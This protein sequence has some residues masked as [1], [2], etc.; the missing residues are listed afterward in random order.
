MRGPQTGGS[1]TEHRNSGAERRIEKQVGAGGLTG[2]NTGRQ[3][4]QQRRR[5]GWRERCQA[6]SGQQSRVPNVL[7]W[8]ARGLMAREEVKRPTPRP[9]FELLNQELELKQQVK[10]ATFEKAEELKKK[11]NEQVD[12]EK[13]RSQ[14]KPSTIDHVWS[15]FPC[16]CVPLR[17][18]AGIVDAGQLN[19]YSD[20][21]V[22]IGIS[23][24]AQAPSKEQ[25]D[26][27][28]QHRSWAQVMGGYALPKEDGEE[29]DEW[30]W[31]NGA[32][33]AAEI[34]RR[35]MRPLL[36][37][38]KLRAHN[39]KDAA[40]EM[41]RR[42]V[43]QKYAPEPPIPSLVPPATPTKSE[44]L[45]Q[46]MAA[47]DAAWKEIKVEMAPLQRKK[48]RKPRIGLRWISPAAKAAMKARNKLQR[49]LPVPSQRT[50]EQQEEMKQARRD[51]RQQLKTAHRETIRKEWEEAGPKAGRPEHWKVFSKWSRR[52]E[53]QKVQPGCS[54]DK[55]QAT[56]TEKLEKIRAPLLKVPVAEV[57]PRE[58]ET[59]NAF[60]KFTAEDVKAALSQAKATMSSGIDEVPMAVLKKV[61]EFAAT[62]I[63]LLANTVVE[64]AEW[65]D[66][67]KKS[68]I[69]PLWKKKDLGEAISEAIPVQFADDISLI[70]IGKTR[71][72]ALKKMDVALKEVN[73]YAIANRLAPQPD[74][75]QMMM[76]TDDCAKDAAEYTC[77]LAGEKVVSKAAIRILGALLDRRLSWEEQATAASGK[78][79]A[80]LGAIRRAARY[81][82]SA[83]RWF[84]ARALAVPHLDYCQTAFA[85]PTVKATAKLRSAYHRAARMA[86]RR[87]R[88]WREGEDERNARNRGVPALVQLGEP[89]WS[90]RRRA[91]AAACVSRIC[92]GRRLAQPD[93]NTAGLKAL[94]A[95]GPRLLNKV[96]A[97]DAFADCEPDPPRPPRGPAIEK[98]AEFSPPSDADIVERRG[99]YAF[100]LA[101]YNDQFPSTECSDDAGRVIVW[102]DG[103]RQTIRD[104][105][106]AGAGVFYGY[107]ALAGAAAREATLKP[108]MC[109]SAPYP[110]VDLTDQAMIRAH[111]LDAVA[112]GGGADRIEQAAPAAMPLPSLSPSEANGKQ[113]DSQLLSAVAIR[114][115]APRV[116]SRSAGNRST[117]TRVSTIHRR[118]TGAP[119]CCEFA[120][121][122]R[123]RGGRC[124]D[125]RRPM[126]EGRHRRFASL[127]FGPPRTEP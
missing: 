88:R 32:E 119:H 84:L 23:F 65:P 91:V 110:K 7:L 96:L 85:A 44:L 80:A 28:S 1:A 102:T 104:K 64:A 46:R 90:R 117:S 121:Q 74:K 14:S 59:F 61:G 107:D 68:Q 83:D 112:D 56:W 57:K 49:E 114:T 31:H 27:T 6:R 39:E 113:Q 21:H 93:A 51:V 22:P 67:W 75:T 123:V 115:L 9:L 99:Y 63:A 71:E 125:V 26:Q 20:G 127:R 70:E 98:K 52:K 35:H 92:S 2:S 5:A 86:T 111:A 60:K 37:A 62:E 18:K 4:Q 118:D 73:A 116:Q 103:S 11:K 40:E 54:A 25:K 13:K 122:P 81:L 69:S 82:S 100:L 8:N 36:P 30:E 105:A 78:A 3:P 66:D 76:V 101:E 97:G 108:A 79:R 124:D 87:E 45:K 77:T 126:K 42:G 34:I 29:D 38:E 43:G 89:I 55:V 15:E 24:S 16:R 95:W 94:S 33:E 19:E 109:E 58:V 12:D 106:Q 41:R 10:F 120:M 50:A 72:E 17:G 48:V 53:R 47:W